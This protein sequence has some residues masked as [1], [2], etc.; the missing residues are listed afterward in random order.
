MLQ[1]LANLMSGMSLRTKVMLLAWG[2]FFLSAYYSFG[3]FTSLNEH[4][5]EAKQI[6]QVV[7]LLRVLEDVTEKLATERGLSLGFAASGGKSF[8]NEL[9]SA[10]RGT[11]AQVDTWLGAI[12]DKH[13]MLSKAGRDRIHDHLDATLALRSKW[14]Q[15]VDA[16]NSRSILHDYSYANRLALDVMSML[17]DEIA[18][19]D[20][21]EDIRV[22]LLLD[23]LIE[24]AAQ[25]RG[26]IGQILASGSATDAQI[27][28]LS[29]L[30]DRLHLVR[31]QYDSFA[32]DAG[33]AALSAVESAPV[34]AKVDQVRR[35]LIKQHEAGQT[36]QGPSLPD[37]FSLASERIGKWSAFSD[38]LK[39][40]VDDLSEARNDKELTHLVIA[41]VVTGVLYIAGLLLASVVVFDISSSV[42]QIRQWTSEMLQ[43]HDLGLRYRTSRQD[44]LGEIGKTIDEFAI[45][46]AEVLSRVQ[47]LS[48]TLSKQASDVADS[49]AKA[50]D[51]IDRQQLES[52]TLSAAIEEMAASIGEVS[53]NTH[54]TAEQTEKASEVSGSGRHQ[55]EETKQS[56]QVLAKRLDQSQQVILKLHDDSNRIGTIVDT[57]NGIAGQTNLLALNAAIEAARAGEQGRGFAVVADE[58]RSLAQRTQDATTEIRN[59]IESLQG[60][61]ETVYGTMTESIKLSENCLAL[62]DRSLQVID[63]LDGLVDDINQSNIQNSA[64]TEE[65]S[66]VAIDISA[67][68]LHISDLANE[69]V[70]LARENARSSEMLKV[71]AND[72]DKMVSQYRLG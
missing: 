25:E 67:N 1:S 47:K 44:E 28:L 10:R 23:E 7:D 20:E 5:L 21:M 31:H 14:R 52:Q 12:A 63:R 13:L 65:Q 27:N 4:R 9:S 26:L 22:I 34:F 60:A 46:I 66:R 2:P 68:T 32:D 17:S 70:T 40:K 39:K 37:W 54:R 62:S 59:M 71:V 43:K 18:R 16:L 36:L 53:R 19:R 8:A 61:S 57:I 58:V 38:G 50:D 24:T 33:E 51:L 72:L 11:D 64:A 69:T 55:V 41:A 3:Y 45:E 6:K 42:R 49:S 29:E 48:D 35:D 30:D 56:I 15:Q